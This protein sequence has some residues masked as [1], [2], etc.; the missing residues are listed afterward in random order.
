MAVMM[1]IVPIASLSLLAWIIDI[2]E[3]MRPHDDYPSFLKHLWDWLLLR[4]I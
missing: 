3:A 4:W 1:F 2:I